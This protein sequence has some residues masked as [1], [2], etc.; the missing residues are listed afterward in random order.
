MDDK[1]NNKQIIFFF[2][3]SITL[4]LLSLTQETFCASSDCSIG[5]F[6][7]IIG[8]FG[9]IF[10]MGFH[11]FAIFT[12]LANPL[13]IISWIVLKKN[14]KLS[15][16][17]SILAF[18]LSFSFLFFNKILVNE[19]GNLSTIKEYKIGYWFW[20]SSSLIMMIGNLYCYKDLKKYFLFFYLNTNKKQKLKEDEL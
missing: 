19:S 17:L 14:K 11:S 5:W 2:I 16:T 15:L 18:L 6:T 7:L 4:Y 8:F 9:N 3:T 10:F 13:L 20:L 1:K 12:W